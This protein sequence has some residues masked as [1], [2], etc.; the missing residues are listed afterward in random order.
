MEM[1]AGD[2]VAPLARRVLGDTVW[3]VRKHGKP[4]AALVRL[5]DALPSKGAVRTF[6]TPATYVTIIPEGERQPLDTL[7]RLAYTEAAAQLYDGCY[8]PDAL[9]VAKQWERER[10]EA[11]PVARRCP[12][13]DSSN[14]DAEFVDVGVGVGG[15]QVTPYDCGDCGAQEMHPG[16]V[17]PVGC[18]QAGGWMRKR[19]QEDADWAPLRAL[20]D[21]EI[22]DIIGDCQMTSHDEGPPVWFVTAEDL[23]ASRERTTKTFGTTARMGWATYGDDE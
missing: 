14:V 3:A 11:Q 13:C 16:D 17:A 21:G 18:D 8:H 6:G 5:R 19:A 15:V 22:H 12:F 4:R 10:A 2:N 9:D 1:S 7:H 23:K 20:T